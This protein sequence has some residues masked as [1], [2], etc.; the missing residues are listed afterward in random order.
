MRYL[1]MITALIGW[2]LA[3]PVAA[4][5]YYYRG[6]PFTQADAPYLLGEHIAGTL[7]LDSA[8]PANRPLA[9]IPQASL[10]SFT[11]ADSQQSRTPTNTTVC[12]LALGTDA[13]GVIN[14]WN[15]W[16]RA[17]DLVAGT[18]RFSLETYNIPGFVGD[19]VGSGDFPTACGNGTLNP[20]AASLT[21]GSWLPDAILT[22][23]FEG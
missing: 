21:A 15:I 20:R 4:Q 13:Q 11:F 23:G 16:M 18:T 12:R 8:L 9:D 22:D 1:A 17:T 5:N 10:V 2:T 6:G 14:A 19:F 7:I 3:A